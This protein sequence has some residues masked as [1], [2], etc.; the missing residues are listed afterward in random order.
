MQVIYNNENEESNSGGANIV[1]LIICTG[2][3][4]RYIEGEY[5]GRLGRR[6]TGI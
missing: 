6:S 2:E 3:V 5:T 1:D 4:G